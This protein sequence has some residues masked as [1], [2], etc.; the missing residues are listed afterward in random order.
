MYFFC[1]GVKCFLALNG[2]GSKWRNRAAILGPDFFQWMRAFFS[3]FVPVSMILTENFFCV[4]IRVMCW[5]P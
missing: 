5:R 1:A 3:V 2:T 4:L